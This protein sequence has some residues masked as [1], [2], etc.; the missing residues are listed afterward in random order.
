MALIHH[1]V[2]GQ[3]A[4]PIVFVH[5]FGCALSDWD[6]QVAHFSPLHQTITVDLR[7]HG[8]SSA[9]AADCSIERYGADVAEVMR[10]LRLPPAMLVGHSLGCRVVIE[11]A[12]QSPQHSAAVILVDGSQFA[13]AMADVLRQ[14]LADPD[15]LATILTEMFTDMF[16][17]S[18][19][20]SVAAF[21]RDRALR[22]PQ[23]I[24][25]RML[26]DLQRY[27]VT[28]LASSLGILRVPVM[29]LQTTYSNENR[30][31]QSLKAG[32]T[33]PYLDML[34]SSV[35]KAR[36]EIIPETGHFPQL[37]EAQQTNRLIES[38]IAHGV[39]ISAHPGPV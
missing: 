33:T 35:A 11:T 39:G 7:G 37:D 31:R 6:A 14:R 29:A 23:P 24:G 4:P 30:Q 9:A 3:G 16:T 20:P 18:S 26:T 32:Q 2:T 10:A 8:K 12:L 28:R 1:V 5:G 34:R 36:I 27:D 38:F 15:G 17:A 22:L 25:E 13:P 21:A 19:E